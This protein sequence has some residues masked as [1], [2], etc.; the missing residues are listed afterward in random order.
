VDFKAHH[1]VQ[2]N[3]RIKSVLS[4]CTG[5]S[6]KDR[7]N[8]ASKEYRKRTK[9]VE[10][11]QKR[12]IEEALARAKA[13]PTNSPFRDKS[14]TPASMEER[15]RVN[16]ELRKEKE[17]AF[18]QEAAETKQRL[19]TRKPIFDLS[20][21]EAAF[22]ECKRRQVAHRKE[23]REDE[24][25]QWEHIRHLQQKVIDRPLLVENYH[26]PEHMR[27]LPELRLVPNH[28]KETVMETQILNGVEHK[29]FLES[30][31]GKEVESIRERQNSRTPLSKIAYPPKV[32]P[33]KVSG[34][35]A[36]MPI[37]VQMHAV[38]HQA[39]FQKSDW[40]EKV[41]EIRQRMDDR[42]KLHEISYPP[43]H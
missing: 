11:H 9:L 23:L 18:A 2:I 1:K 30:A 22:K 36:L 27:S 6:F 29:D 12:L 41:R 37:E 8:A 17:R 3:S 14:L 4:E 28:S 13:K 16:S 5:A 7:A 19:D 26:R 42:P 21:V 10:D 25:R 34:P 24:E 39:W 38:T 35:R 40:A 43:K 32:F 20:E 33:P 31:W 15:Y